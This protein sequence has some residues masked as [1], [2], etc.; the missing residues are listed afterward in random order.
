MNHQEIYDA[1]HKENPSGWSYGNETL[2]SD[3]AS[4]IKDL[5]E[6]D[7]KK[8]DELQDVI[9]HIELHSS[10]ETCAYIDMTTEQRKVFID[11]LNE[12]EFVQ[13][14][15]EQPLTEQKILDSIEYKR[16]HRARIWR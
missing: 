4:F 14:G 12:N 6:K 5:M 2:S 1:W 13:S 8:I 3:M 9:R 11:A 10:Y 7:Q 15:E 16:Q